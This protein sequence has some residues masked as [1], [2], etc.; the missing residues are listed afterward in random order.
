MAAAA[1]PRRSSA[2]L[3]LPSEDSDAVTPLQVVNIFSVDENQL[4]YFTSAASESGIANPSLT[5]SLS[6]SGSTLSLA[7]KSSVS[8]AVEG[9]P[10]LNEALELV[11]V[12]GGTALRSY[13]RPTWYL[14]ARL[15]WA[16][17]M[18]NAA[19]WH[20]GR[21]A[22]PAAASQA[23]G[24][25]APARAVTA[26]TLELLQ[27]NIFMAFDPSSRRFRLTRGVHPESILQIKAVPEDDKQSWKTLESLRQ[28]Q[29]RQPGTQSGRSGGAEDNAYS[30]EAEERRRALV[31][32][33]VR[34]ELEYGSMLEEL[35]TVCRWQ[36]A[37]ERAGGPESQRRRLTGNLFFFLQTYMDALAADLTADEADQIFINVPDILRFQLNLCAGFRVSLPVVAHGGCSGAA[38]PI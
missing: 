29:L 30:E 20:L 16:A 5:D 1:S 3:Q 2:A 15:Q 34:S 22:A 11:L 18:S 25:V 37:G 36:R 32:D 35:Q 33:L 12:P 7:P 26:A 17:D 21:P 24:E 23:D 6:L 28:L 10:G 27:R 38:N 14:T 19:R 8:N 13:A 9:P 31:R 4:F